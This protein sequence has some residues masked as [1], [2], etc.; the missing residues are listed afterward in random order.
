MRFPQPSHHERSPRDPRPKLVHPPAEPSGEPSSEPA[1]GRSQSIEWTPSWT[2]DASHF[3][4]GA[5]PVVEGHYRIPVPTHEVWTSPPRQ[6]LYK[7]DQ[8][9]LW[10]CEQLAVTS[11][12]ENGAVAREHEAELW[13]NGEAAHQLEIKAKQARAL[14]KQ[15]TAAGLN[16]L[17]SM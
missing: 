2:A 8:S 5:A 17:G 9:G 16:V 10:E 4:K 12:R 15:L 7:K 1:S 6:H 14:N 11:R 3:G 13:R